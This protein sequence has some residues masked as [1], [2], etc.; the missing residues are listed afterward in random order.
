MPGSKRRPRHADRAEIVGMTVMLD[1]LPAVGM[2]DR[3]Q[4]NA[5]VGS[6]ASKAFEVN[7]AK[8]QRKVDRER[9]QRERGSLP[10]L[11]AEPVHS[12]TK[13]ITGSRDPKLASARY[14]IFPSG[15]LRSGG[16]RCAPTD[17]KVDAI[18]TRC[19]V[20]RR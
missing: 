18:T 11:G 16:A 6:A 9:E 17:S 19:D 1:G 12:E 4:Q 15:Q 3:R 13:A 10:G 14:R 7:V 5:G 8:R 20:G 2:G